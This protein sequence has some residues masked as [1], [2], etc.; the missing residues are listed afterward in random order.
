MARIR[1]RRR[2]RLR[3]RVVVAAAASIVV[4]V[5]VLGAAVQVLLARHLHASLDSTLRD[6]AAAIARLS[7]SAPA[8]LTSPSVLE[9][10]VGPHPIEVE[11][12]DRHARIV[13]PL[14]PPVGGQML[15]V[16]G[17]ASQVI[18][19][20]R[21][22][23]RN[24][25]LGDQH[26]RVYV[27]PLAA[28][29]GPASGGAVIVAA[30]TADV[31]DTL[32]ESRALIILS[33]LA[34]AGLVVPIAFVLTGRALG[35]LRRL[36]AGAEVIEARGDPSLRLPGAGDDGRTP[37]EVERL[38][39][40]LNR[41]LAALERARDAERRFVAD[42]SHELRNPLTA[43]RGNAAYLARNGADQAALD[44]LRA[45][46]DRLSRLVDEL[47]ALAREDAGGPPTE[48]VRLDELAAEVEGERVQVRLDDPGL[49][50]GDA[51]AL[52]RALANLVDNALRHGPAGGEVSVTV[53]RVGDR[54]TL[55]VADQGPGI[56]TELVELAT[57]RFW[58][59]DQARSQE[60]S[61]L[62]L[63][64]V[65]ATAERHGGRLVID[66]ARIA[67]ELPSLTPLSSDPD[68]TRDDGT[69]EG[70]VR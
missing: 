27:A 10:S 41:M 16:G 55:A 8:L 24:S 17:L 40:T 3:T 64:L 18:R 28:L 47:L 23:Y 69:N 51:G 56:P 61:G 33:A 38:A 60:G 37:D 20:G 6:R 63:S 42:A 12:V 4:A 54:V 31:T 48:P 65:R 50:Q 36:A 11:V 66:G 57:R 58:R 26:V 30:S 9:A 45:D 49:V 32:A 35:P 14:S 21:G 34:A 39:E 43:L 15:E 52:R 22:A 68:T 62:G 13:A 70:A 25:M 59:G 7:A 44:D 29:G 67:I 46:A 53:S 19:S 5:V 1:L 2:P